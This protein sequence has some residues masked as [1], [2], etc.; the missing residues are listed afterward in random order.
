MKTVESQIAA[1]AAEWPT[2]EVVFRN[3]RRAVWEGNLTPFE[4]T[5]RVRITYEAPVAPEVF[6]IFRIAPRIRVLTPPLEEHED[7]ELGPLPH[8]FWRGERRDIPELCVFDPEA[9]EW[10]PCD[11]LAFTTV[12]WTLRWLV[13][14][15]GWLATKAWHGR[16]RP[17]EQYPDRRFGKDGAP[18][19]QRDRWLTSTVAL[20][21]R[22]VL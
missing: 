20:A 13:H 8:V 18:L 3:G 16:G 6:R 1:M 12:R 21:A 17:H 4:T 11:L 5:Y 19:R 14:Y 15:E 10:S 2:L 9:E 7:Y 22:A